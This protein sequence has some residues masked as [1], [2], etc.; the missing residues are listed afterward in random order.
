MKVKEMRDEIV[1]LLQSDG[2]L[3]FTSAAA[4]STKSQS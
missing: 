1:S 4:A 2:R 3:C